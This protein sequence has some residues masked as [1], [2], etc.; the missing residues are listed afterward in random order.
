M[1]LGDV[2]WVQGEHDR[3][4]AHYEEAVE[5]RRGIGDLLLICDAVYNLGMAAFQGG[6]AE[7]AREAFEEALG[8]ARELGEAQHTAAAQ[9]MLA[10]LDLLE[11][12]PAS[13]AERARESLALYGSFE[14]DRSCARCLAILGGAA[15]AEGSAEDAAHLLGAASALRQGQSPDGFEQPILDEYLPQLESALGSRK[16]SELQAEGGRLRADV[17]SREVVSAATRE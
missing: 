3:A 14:D 4:I 16:L 11:G 9:F 15:A 17:M 6:D 8:H 13:A 1:S 5:L 12:D 10:E 7:R 2:C